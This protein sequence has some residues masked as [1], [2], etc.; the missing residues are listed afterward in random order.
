M[1]GLYGKH[2]KGQVEFIIIIGIL[3]VV[4]VVVVLALQGTGESPLPSDSRT[5][6]SS[7][8]SFIR[9]GAYDTIKTIGLQGGYLTPPADTVTFLGNSVPYWQKGGQITTPDLSTNLA[10]GIEQYIK[11]NKDAI[12]SSFGKPV[13]LGE[14]QVSVTV[15]ASNVDLAVYMPTTI[16]GTAVAQ[17]YTISIPTKIGDIHE[18]GKGFVTENND[19]RFFEI[20][21]LSSIALSP[22][23]ED[24][25]QVPTLIF[26]TQC[27]E[28]VL[29]TWWDIQPGMTE[30]I[31]KTIANTYMPGK[32]PRNVGESSSSAKYMLTPIKGKNYADIEVGFFLPDDF[33]LTRQN[34]AMTPEPIN[35]YAKPIP[36]TGICQ[37][38]PINVEYF[39]EYPVL[40]RAEDPLT[41]LAFQFAVDV[42]IQDNQPALWAS[43]SSY[44]LTDL[45]KLC[46][47][48][49][50]S[51]KL[52]VTDSTGSPVPYA[53]ATFLNC[54][55]GRA[56]EAGV[57]EADVPCGIGTLNVYKSGFDIYDGIWSSDSLA[58][59]EVALTKTPVVNLHFY[60]VVIDD[61]S[62]ISEYWINKGAIRPI[63]NNLRDGAVRM[64]VYEPASHELNEFLFM[65]SVGRLAGV[66]AGKQAFTTILYENLD[67]PPPSVN[68]AMG[69]TFT[70][71]EDLDG[72]DLY[73]Y[74]P[75]YPQMDLSGDDVSV[76]T[77]TGKLS[78]ILRKC[79]IG[80]ITD[81]EVDEDT[82][83][84]LSYSDALVIE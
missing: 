59:A 4:A 7:I 65:E 2:R 16:D 32:G 57:L 37:S 79:G 64:T 18:F 31:E 77:E 43:L 27:G 42:A 40:V 1:L 49:Q 51:M 22:L 12:A 20:F 19:K 23:D 36:M 48:P 50:C 61:V 56:D 34:F 44:E 75:Y 38:D 81:T 70:I 60:D 24:I 83:C 11:T 72:K 62:S 21:T 8:E 17:P 33:E 3:V 46:S 63:D 28:F 54:P 13:T 15:M 5:I 29:K 35:T 66:P 80:P 55:A 9:A 52:L 53:S 26:L 74:L 14:P 69:T 39:V 58:D 6:K 73:V 71:T 41:G 45:G 82:T 10:D 84:T 76:S 78:N 47:N 68:G 30:A 25:Q 67:N